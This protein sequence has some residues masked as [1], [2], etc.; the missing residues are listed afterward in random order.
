[1]ANIDHK[2]ITD[3]N[4]H[5]PKNISAANNDEVYVANGGGSGIWKRVTAAM[6]DST[7][8]AFGKILTALGDGTSSYDVAVWKDLI[9]DITPKTS[10]VGAPSLGAFRGGNVRGFAYSAGDDGDAVFHIPHD[11]KMGSD[12][13]LHLHWGH[14]GTAI[15]GSLLVN[16]YVTYAK[17]HNQSAFSTEVTAPISVSTPDIVT[18]PQYRHRI[19]EIQLSSLTPSGSQIN[20]SLIEPDGIIMVHFDVVTIPTIT[21]GT[22]NEPFLFTLDIHYQADMIGTLNKAPNFYA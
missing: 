12:L 22:P 6:V 3:P 16:C 1:M 8:K 9:G 15:S 13:F 14:N 21:G 4:I 10:G 20:T 18:V 2:N 17:G 19:D 7:G 11:Y 5:E